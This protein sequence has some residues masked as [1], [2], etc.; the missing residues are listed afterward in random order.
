[1]LSDKL[2]RLKPSDERLL[3]LGG[4]ERTNIEIDFDHAEMIEQINELKH[5]GGM[6][7]MESAE[8]KVEEEDI[9]LL[10]GEDSVQIKTDSELKKGLSS[11]L[12][13]L[14]F[15]I[16]E[17]YFANAEK[18]LDRLKKEFP[19]S[20][21]IVSRL[22]R[23]KKPIPSNPNPAKQN[24]SKSHLRSPRKVISCRSSKIPKSVSIWTIS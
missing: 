8:I 22:A 18:I 13:E 19:E 4:H 21:E 16:S 3:D 10:K 1:V 11:H 6:E 2:T 23:I 15:Y 20:K 9:F 14:D 17:G 24:R 7:E 5:P 12:A